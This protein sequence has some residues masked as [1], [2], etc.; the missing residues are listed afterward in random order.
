M[1]ERFAEWCWEDPERARRLLGEYNRRFNCI[2]LR[3]YRSE[4]ER[5][6][7]PGLARSVHPDAASARRGR[8]DARRARRR[9]VSPG[10]RRQDRG[11]DH[12]RQRAAPPRDGQKARGRGAQPHARAVHSRVA[13]ALSR[14][15]G[16]W[17]PPARTSPARSAAS[18]SPAPPANDWDAV[19]HDPLGVRTHPRHPETQARYMRARARRAA[20]DARQRARPPAA[21]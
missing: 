5:L 7:L 12:R 1:Q 15:R 18:S 14:R 21:G 4:G 20:R 16:S 10:R 17:P 3:D 13:A 19:H 11:D 6:T 2:V 8:A 9:A